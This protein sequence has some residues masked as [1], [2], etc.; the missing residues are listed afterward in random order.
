MTPAEQVR[1]KLANL[2]QVITSHHPTLPVLLRD[3]HTQ[4]KKDPDVVTILTP[5]E[6]SILVSGLSKQTGIELASV[7]MKAS[8]KPMKSIGVDD[9]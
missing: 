2:Q 9:L 1:E 7:A 6:I 8:K 5:E 3:I 4:L